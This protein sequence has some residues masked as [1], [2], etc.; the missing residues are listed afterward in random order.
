MDSIIRKKLQNQGFT[1]FRGVLGD[2]ARCG[3][4]RLADADGRTDTRKQRRKRRAKQSK[5]HSNIIH[6]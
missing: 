5:S 6:D 2:D 3:L 4:A 1:E